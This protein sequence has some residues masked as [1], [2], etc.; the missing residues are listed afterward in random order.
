MLYDILSTASSTLLLS[1]SPSTCCLL[2]SELGTLGLF[3]LS[4]LSALFLCSSLLLL[5]LFL[6][7]QVELFGYGSEYFFY[8]E[9][10]LC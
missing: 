9:A 1:G 10:G 8:V 4:L 7:L 6:L 2:R 3:K 5:L